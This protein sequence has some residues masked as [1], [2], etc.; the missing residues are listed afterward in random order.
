MSQPRPP[1]APTKT[2]TIT[3]PTKSRRWYCHWTGQVNS[4]GRPIYRAP[5]H[6]CKDGDHLIFCNLGWC[7]LQLCQDHQ[8]EHKLE[9]TMAQLAG[10]Q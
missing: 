6:Q 4:E 1:K 5:G 7:R 8:E 10:E 9:H 2:I 3:V